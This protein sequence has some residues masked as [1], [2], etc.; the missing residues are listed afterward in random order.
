M[1]T[2][3]TILHQQ[4]FLWQQGHHGCQM[5]S[6]PILSIEVT[7]TI[8]TVLNYDGDF[9]RHGH[10]TVTCKHIFYVNLTTWNE[11]K[12]NLNDIV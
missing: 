9:D 2:Y 10:R 3:P 1:S 7:I 4:W 12:V 6:G 5:G 11:T 8:D